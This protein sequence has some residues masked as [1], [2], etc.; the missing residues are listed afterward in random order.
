MEINNCMECNKTLRGRAD[1]KFCTSSCRNSYHNRK[2][3]YSTQM[4]RDINRVLRKNRKILLQSNPYGKT[5]ISKK[6]LSARGFD[7]NYYTNT[8]QDLTGDQY[9]FCYDQ[10]Y[11]MEENDRYLLI[12]RKTI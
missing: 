3:G 8:L 7:F 4:V 9:Y 5:Q 11:I 10:G 12:D 2:K 1:K 6:Q